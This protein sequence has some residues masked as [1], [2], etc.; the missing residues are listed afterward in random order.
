MIKRTLAAVVLAAA[1]LP[2]SASAQ[3]VAR[4]VELSDATAPPR[5]LQYVKPGAVSRSVPR[6]TSEVSAYKWDGNALGPQRQDFDGWSYWDGPRGQ[7]WFDG[8]GFV[9]LT[10]KPVI[11][12]AWCS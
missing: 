9:N 8:I 10:R 6:C 2:A 12:A 7:V 1:I 4:A 11:V 5:F 3:P